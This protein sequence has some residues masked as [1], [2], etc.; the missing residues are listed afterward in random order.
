MLN[1]WTIRTRSFLFA[2]A[3]LFPTTVAADDMSESMCRAFMPVMENA[4]SFR[5]Q[6]IPIQSTKDM[7][8][9]AFDLD[10]NLYRFLISSI[11]FTYQNPEAAAVSLQ[12]GSLLSLCVQQVRGF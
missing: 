1:K 6:G 4:Y 10:V 8:S 3:L 5:Q 7:A 2:T 12:D 9:S 11:E